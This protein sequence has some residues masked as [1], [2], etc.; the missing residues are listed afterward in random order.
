MSITVV[1]VS[2]PAT[3]TTASSY[4]V[5]LPVAQQ[6]DLVVVAYGISNAA[7]AALGINTAGYTEIANLY[8]NDDHDTNL[9]VAYKI[10]GA[11]PDSL[12]NVTGPSST[13]RGGGAVAIVLRGVNTSTPIDVTTTTATGVN[14]FTPDPPTITPVTAGAMV[15]AI[16]AAS[17]TLADSVGTAP[18]GYENQV[19][20]SI[21]GIVDSFLVA[22]AAKLWSGSGAEDPGQFTNYA[23]GTASAGSWAGV[24]VAI[25][26]AVSSVP[27]G[28][29]LIDPLGNCTASEVSGN[30]E[31][32]IPSGGTTHDLFN[33]NQ[34]APILYA[35]VS[36]VNFELVTKYVGDL[37][38]GANENKGFG[39]VAFDANTSNCV[40]FA[41]ASTTT[42]GLKVRS[43]AQSIV[44]NV[45]TTQ[46]LAD[47]STNLA[48]SFYICV[49]RT[50]DVWTF[51]TSF[52]GDT[53]TQKAQ[54]T[55]ALTISK[56]GL[57][58]TNA[59]SSPPAHL[60]KFDYLIPDAPRQG[61]SL[62]GLVSETASASESISGSGQVSIVGSGLIVEGARGPIDYAVGTI[63]VEA[64][65][66][67][68]RY[69]DRVHETTQT[70]G[71]DDFVLDGAF[72][73]DHKRISDR[74]VEGDVFYYTV[75]SRVAGGGW[76]TGSGTLDALGKLVRTSVFA[77]SIAD[78]KIDFGSGVKD[79]I[80][81]LNS[82]Y[83]NDLA[84]RLHA[85]TVRLTNAGI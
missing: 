50:G 16:G 52:D 11:T 81:A 33:T 28:F 23:L 58:A 20:A 66:D 82:Y 67:I 31:I 73:S 4:N 9:A 27:A 64:L 18:S 34:N 6:N 3:A 83:M 54:F 53:W 14:S 65:Q 55:H 80:I 74:Y 85:I 45:S 61:P 37:T 12:I 47:L 51:F 13:S 7:D 38:V 35:P 76:E 1:G 43:F 40:S 57:Y 24:T 56:V 2:S 78:A 72:S 32:S 71:L 10:M 19:A 15:L 63:V 75:I 41:V 5:T 44:A 59:G 39:I 77:S 21:A 70:T 46:H 69:Y 8:A 29:T 25:R 42:G 48:Q 17:G 62:I 26:P 36:N 22:L 84:D 60:A 30:L 49:N 79:V 68:P